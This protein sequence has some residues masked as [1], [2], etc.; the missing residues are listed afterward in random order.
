MMKNKLLFLLTYFQAKFFERACR[1][2]E[3]SFNKNWKE[4]KKLLLKENYFWQ[5]RGYSKESKLE[6]FPITTYEDYEQAMQNSLQSGLS[7]FTGEKVIFGMT[8]SGTSGASKPFLMTKSYQKQYQ[9]VTA[10]FIHYMTRLID[11]GKGKIIYL[12]SLDSQGENAGFKVAMGTIGNFTYRKIPWFLKQLYALPNHLLSS[13]DR[14]KSLAPYYALATDVSALYAVTPPIAINFLENIFKHQDTRELIETVLA[15]QFRA[16]YSIK[17]SKKR[18]KLLNRL[19]LKT[20][21]ITPKDVWPDLQMLSCWTSS[22]CKLSLPKLKEL[23]DDTAIADGIY[24][25]TEGW[26][27]VQTDFERQGSVYHPR[28][29][30]LEFLPQG[31]QLDPANLLKPWQIK[32]GEEYEVF[33]TNKMGLVRYRIGDVLKCTGFFFESPVLQFQRKISSSLSLGILRITEK[34]LISV[35][36]NCIQDYNHYFFAANPSGVG[37]GFY[38]HQSQQGLVDQID[39]ITTIMDQHL[40]QLNLDYKKERLNGTL[41]PLEAFLLEESSHFCFNQTGQQKPKIIITSPDTA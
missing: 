2:I 6:N 23:T 40:Q 5:E 26:V 11:Y 3:S 12:I 13:A 32:M 27:C 19:L 15:P 9:I 37:L 36:K 7:Q 29:C 33:Y 16:K 38:Y 14:F 22:V 31:E 35:A 24:S 17:L 10:P 21:S 28:G 1:Q 8:T 4:T 34:Q 30:L 39:E 25:A 18:E 41:N 20:D